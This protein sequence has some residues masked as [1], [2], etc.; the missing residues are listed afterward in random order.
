ML[1]CWG[2]DVSRKRE[3]RHPGE[4]RDPF[5]LSARHPVIPNIF[6]AEVFT[7]TW[8]PA[9]AGMTDLFV[10]PSRSPQ[11]RFDFLSPCLQRI[12]PDLRIAGAMLIAQRGD[13]GVVRSE[14]VFR[15]SAVAGQA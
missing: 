14:I 10:D 2:N 15:Q 6:E 13:A 5:C 1:R 12:Q 4:S 7:A 11:S 8:V 3:R 9:F